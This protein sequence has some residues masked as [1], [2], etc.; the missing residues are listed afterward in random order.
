MI[1]QRGSSQNRITLNRVESTRIKGVNTHPSEH[2]LL[3]KNGRQEC[4]M[5]GKLCPRLVSPEFQPPLFLKMSRDKNRSAVS[6]RR[7]RSNHPM[8]SHT[9]PLVLYLL[10]VLRRMVIPD[11]SMTSLEESTGDG[12]SVSVRSEH[13]LFLLVPLNKF[14]SP[15]QIVDD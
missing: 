7:I 1:Q 4:S 2:A 12:L 3:K 14:S 6:P 8:P 13:L 15:V 10:N 11:C 9:I 5:C